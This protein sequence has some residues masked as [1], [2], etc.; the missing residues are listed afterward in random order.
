MA[1]DVDDLEVETETRERNGIT[2]FD[3][4]VDRTDILPGGTENRDPP[5]TE[6]LIHAANVVAVVVGE[7]DGGELEISLF[8]NLKDERGFAGIH[9]YR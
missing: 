5:C 8:E 6:K 9:D 3:R 1:G 7:E 4:V 2:A